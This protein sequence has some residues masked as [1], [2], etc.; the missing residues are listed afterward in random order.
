MLA[1]GVASSRVRHAIEGLAS[2]LL[3]P[4]ATLVARGGIRAVSYAVPGEDRWVDARGHVVTG[5]PGPS[6][7]VDLTDG[8]GPAVRLELSRPGGQAG[9]RGLASAT[10]LALANARLAAVGRAGLIEVQASQRRIVD[11]RDGERRRI[12][13]DLHDGVQQRLVSVAFHLQVAMRHADP[14]R[15]APRPRRDRGPRGARAAAGLAHGVFPAA[16][17]DEGLRPALEDLVTGSDVGRELD[18]QVCGD[19]TGGGGDGGLRH[20]QCRALGGPAGGGAV[21]HVHVGRGGCPDCATRVDIA[22]SAIDPASVALAADRV[23]AL[24]GRLTVADDGTRVTAVI[25]CG[26]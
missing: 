12:D 9:R 25:P 1:V 15:P 16:L 7:V 8:S 4:E 23:G 17:T 6:T 11:T 21:V 10:R 13:R 2:D 22:G 5:P 18:V 14:G 24:G 26:S 20:R 19:P 3:D